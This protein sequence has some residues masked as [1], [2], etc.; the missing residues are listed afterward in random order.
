MSKSLLSPSQKHVPEM[1]PPAYQE[2]EALCKISTAPVVS[3][4]ELELPEW[5]YEGRSYWK[6]YVV[7]PD[8]SEYTQ[9]GIGSEVG[10]Q[11]ELFF[12]CRM[13]PR[14]PPSTIGGSLQNSLPIFAREFVQQ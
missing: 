6:R 11:P 5:S 10:G 7:A 8:G 3:R 12:T 13:V 2:H 4:S 9:H 14:G 1:P